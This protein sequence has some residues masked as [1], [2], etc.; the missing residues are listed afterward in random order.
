MARSTS[1]E[2]PVLGSCAGYEIHSALPFKALRAAGGAPLRVILGDG[3]APEG[4]VVARW[5]ARPGNPFHGHLLRAGRSFAF[6]AS[7]AGWF[8][9]DPEEGSI[10][11]QGEGDALRRELRLFGIPI[12]ICTLAAGDLSLHASAVEIDGRAVLLAAPSMHGKTTLAAGFAA[13]GHR[14]LAED[15]VR[16][17]LDEAPRVYPGPAVVR[18]RADMAA[19]LEVPA[20]TRLP[21]LDE[22]RTPFLFAADVRGDGSPLPLAAVVMLRGAAA[23]PRMEVVA[24]A[25]AVRDLFSLAF[26]LPTNDS[27]ATCFAQVADLASRVSVF[28]LERPRSVASLPDVV[29][30]VS[31]QVRRSQP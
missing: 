9:I 23:A 17:S 8:L 20:T 19:S 21:A 18:L 14:L 1:T 15:T 28:N 2:L 12:A 10:T 6:W 4:E 27:R 5:S 13:G 24:G 26:R 16:C 7:D 31:D 3:T 29:A 30:L 22:G 25:T 11:V